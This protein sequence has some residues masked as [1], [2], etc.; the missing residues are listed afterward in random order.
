ML[1]PAGTGRTS[2]MVNLAGQSIETMVA[3]HTRE[4]VWLVKVNLTCLPVFLIVV[5]STSYH[6]GVPA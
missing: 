6:T 4:S 1:I 3:A 2:G 5:R